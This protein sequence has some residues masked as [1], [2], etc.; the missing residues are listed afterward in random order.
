MWIAS[1]AGEIVAVG[2]GY[3]VRDRLDLD[4]GA[5]IID[6][7]GLV[8]VPGSDRLP[9]A[10]LLRRRPRGRVRA[11]RAA[12][13]RTRRS[14]RAAAASS[15]PVRATREA[16]Q[17]DLVDAARGEHLAAMLEHG[18]TTVEVKSGYGLD[19][20]TEQLMLRAIQEAGYESA[21]HVVGT[22]LAA[23]AVP[24][25]SR[26]RGRLHH[27]SASTRSCPRSR[28]GAS[29]TRPTCSASAARSTSTQAR[30]YLEAA[31]EH[32]LALRLHGDQFAEIGALELAIELGARSIDHLEATGAEGIAKLAASDVVGVALPTAALTL[33]RP[34]P[35]ARALVDAGGLLALATDFNPGS[36][37][38]DSLPAVMHLACTQC[39]LSPAEAL[40]AV[41]VNA[42]H[43]L[44][45]GERAGRLR[46]GQRADIALLDVP[47]WRYLAYRLGSEGVKH[48][49]V[50][51]VWALE[52]VDRCRTA[53]RR[54]AA[55]SCA[56]TARAPTPSARRPTGRKEPRPAAA[57]A[58]R[59]ALAAARAAGA[60]A[61]ALRAQGRAARDLH[62]RDRDRDDA[63]R[64]RALGRPSRSPRRSRSSSSSCSSTSGSRARSTSASPASEAP[65][66]GSSR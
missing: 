57:P 31:R 39:H 25:D 14:T 45:I 41:T 37:P 27:S 38:C 2:H 1:Y 4:D 50:E 19:G 64:R 62:V 5:I 13:P 55:A 36:S 40:S 11:A 28:S 48:V 15:R 65:A 12:A 58:R 53:S 32:G 7:P 43:V 59:S 33:G 30:R 26:E 24:E 21:A 35:P 22:C 18:A 42:A 23:H 49:I 46:V 47:D 10:R 61:Q 6:A 51:G 52:G 34:L 66:R 3:E 54:S 20:E 16:S 44:G 17:P 29:P 63:R 60:V 9:Y 8:A 56:C